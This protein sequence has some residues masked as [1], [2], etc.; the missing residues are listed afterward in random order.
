MSLL[1]L[2]GV[3]FVWTVHNLSNHQKRYVRWEKT[4]SRLLARMVQS[5]IVHCSVA[6]PL[7]VEK[8]NVPKRKIKVIPHGH[9]Q[10]WYPALSSRSQA[11]EDLGIP[12]EEIVI[13]YFGHIRPYKGVDRLMED[14]RSLKDLKARLVVIGEAESD[15][16]AEHI[17]TLASGDPRIDLQ[18]RFLPDPELIEYLSA[19]NVA[20]LPYV[21]ILT[22]GSAILAAGCGRTI[23]APAIGCLNEFPK[24]ILYNPA[25][26]SGLRSA[27]QKVGRFSQ[28][29]LDS[30]GE[31]AKVFVTQNGWAK[32]GKMLRQLY[33]QVAY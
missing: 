33:Q 30:K 14:F 7:V 28:E 15:H 19:C 10:D 29:D 11:R 32:T 25:D 8:F 17:K 16:L 5:L 3:R 31:A 4:A 2:A 12:E 26:S 27:L 20:A 6:V 24:Q 23:L 18:L 13:L 1:K 22:S 9:Y 21:D